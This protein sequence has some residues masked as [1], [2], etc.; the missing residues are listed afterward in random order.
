M[1]QRGEIESQDHSGM[2]FG[3]V[4]SMVKEFL[5]GEKNLLIM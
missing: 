1:N 2:S 3:L 4:C 5:K